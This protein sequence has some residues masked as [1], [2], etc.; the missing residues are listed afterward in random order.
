MTCYLSNSCAWELSKFQCWFNCLYACSLEVDQHLIFLG[1]KWILCLVFITQAPKHSSSSWAPLEFVEHKS[2]LMLLPY[3]QWWWCETILWSGCNRAASADL[4]W[5]PLTL[6][7][8]IFEWKL[9]LRRHWSSCMW[10]WCCCFSR[11]W[12]GVWALTWTLQY[13]DGLTLYYHVQRICAWLHRLR[14]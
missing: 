14:L 5:F 1:G 9:D 3:P 10:W 2:A 7:L 4:M 8:A 6:P 12:V 11:F 13:G